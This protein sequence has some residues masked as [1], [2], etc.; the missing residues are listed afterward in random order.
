VDNTK[1]FTSIN[2]SR[3]GVRFRVKAR[4]QVWYHAGLEVRIRGRGSLGIVQ[5]F[6][7]F[8]KEGGVYKVLKGLGLG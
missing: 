5:R 4:S 6:R 7:V 2:W 1:G 8:R 3:V